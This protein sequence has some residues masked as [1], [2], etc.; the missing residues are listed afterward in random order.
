MFQNN[1]KY[2]A[3]D[4]KTGNKRTITYHYEGKR[5]IS[6]TVHGDNDLITSDDLTYSF[7]YNDYG[8]VEKIN[9]AGNTLVTNNYNNVGDNTY[10]GQVKSTK[11]GEFTLGYSYDDQGRVIEIHNIVID[12]AGEETSIILVE[13]L[14]DALG[15]IA[16]V[17]DYKEDEEGISYYYN[18]DIENRLVN[19]N[20]SNG[21]HVSYEYD[22]IDGLLEKYNN[23]AWNVSY[24]YESIIE[25]IPNEE[26]KGKIKKN[27]NKVLTTEDFNRFKKEY[28]YVDK[29]LQKIESSSIIIASSSILSNS[30]VYEKNTIDNQ[31]YEKFRVK[32]LVIKGIDTTPLYRFV[33]RYDEYDNIKS[34]NFYKNGNLVESEYFFYDA[35][36]QLIEHKSNEYSSS[37]VTKYAYDDRG[38]ITSIVGDNTNIT[39]TY[40]SS[41]WLDQLKQVCINGENKDISRYDSTGNPL[42]YFDYT[43]TYDE[44]RRITSFTK[45]DGSQFSYKYNASGYRTSKSINGKL[46]ST[47]ILDG[48]K[49]IKEYR[50]D[51]NQEIVY[52]YDSNDNIIGLSYLGNDYFYVKNIQNDIIGIVNSSGELVVEYR[53][54]TY[55]QVTYSTNSNLANINPYRYRSYYYDSESKFYYCNSRYYNPEICRW[56]NADNINYLDYSS[57]NGV[58]LY[59]YCGN[60]SIMHEDSNGYDYTTNKYETDCVYPVFTVWSSYYS[61]IYGD[62]DI[63]GCISLNT[64]IDFVENPTYY[65]SFTEAANDWALKY[66]NKSV[67]Y[68]TNIYSRKRS[69]KSVYFY[70]NTYKGKSNNVVVGFI[71][72][73]TEPSIASVKSGWIHS[74]PNKGGAS[75]ADEF[76]LYLPN[77]RHGYYVNPDLSVHE[78]FKERNKGFFKAF[79][80][81][82]TNGHG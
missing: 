12:E 62:G 30:Y 58:N 42:S 36:N 40:E 75:N 80:D 47:Y 56:I 16:K 74:H 54:S 69:G 57:I 44:S 59:A 45:K 76:L 51:L 39:F 18:Y 65:D 11:Y 21:N 27:T 73:Y 78:Y 61:S 31:V 9:V 4:K 81:M 37:K 66:G 41:G 25:E 38:N 20:S 48:S 1:T 70:K 53:Y 32:E 43:V 52:Y 15:N 22:E 35:F 77:M 33:Y 19:I 63:D 3:I 13:Y 79:Y 5:L 6:F 60:N 17:V 28:N 8:D 50:H 34:I 67:E 23:I 7:V 68:C 71:L 26:D 64:F 29:A 82:V 55:G 2:S 46:Q 14:Y 24:G 72:S 10:K 49:I